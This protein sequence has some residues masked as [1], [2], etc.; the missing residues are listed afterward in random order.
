[1]GICKALLDMLDLARLAVDLLLGLAI[2]LL[3]LQLLKL[4][5]EENARHVQYTEC[6]LEV[7]VFLFFLLTLTLGLAYSQLS[8]DGLT[9]S[10]LPLPRLNHQSF[11]RQ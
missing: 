6:G 5:I 10:R 1:M 8:I 9:L 11:H 7:I 4:A 3:L 2:G